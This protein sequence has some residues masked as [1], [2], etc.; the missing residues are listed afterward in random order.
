M[1][2]TQLIMSNTRLGHGSHV[3]GTWL[4]HSWI[5]AGTQIAHL[6]LTVGTQLSLGWAPMDVQ[7]PGTTLTFSSSCTVFPRQHYPEKE[8]K[9]EEKVPVPKSTAQQHCAR[10][11]VPTLCCWVHTPS[12]QLLPAAQPLRWHRERGSHGQ[13]GSH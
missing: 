9:E 1:A 12:A 7:C 6:W 3:A 4:A 11:D 13:V 8:E 2:G 10:S 5:T